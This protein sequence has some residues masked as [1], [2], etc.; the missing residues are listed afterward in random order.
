[1]GGDVRRM[2]GDPYARRSDPGGRS[3]PRR[4]RPGRAPRGKEAGGRGRGD[5][6]CKGP[7]GKLFGEPQIENTMFS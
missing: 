5:F 6:V 4:E 7:N 2:R 1:M 3:C